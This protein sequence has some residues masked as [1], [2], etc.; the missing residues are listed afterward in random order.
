M[1][2]ESV[3]KDVL[4]VSQSGSSEMTFLQIRSLN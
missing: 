1:G 4:V 3:L 2:S